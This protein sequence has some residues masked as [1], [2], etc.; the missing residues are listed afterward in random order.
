MDDLAIIHHMTPDEMDD[1]KQAT[2]R[3]FV[4]DLANAHWTM[5]VQGTGAN[6]V[7]FWLYSVSPLTGVRL[8]TQLSVDGYRL[9]MQMKD[10]PA[11]PKDFQP[12]E[13]LTSVLKEHDKLDLKGRIKNHETL[14][15]TLVAYARFTQT[16]E[17]L[18]SPGQ[19]NG[20]HF[21]IFD[22]PTNKGFHV[23]RPIALS[24]HG[25]LTQEAVVAA[26]DK[27]FDMHLAKNPGEF[28]FRQ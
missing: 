19:V 1:I 20:I 12:W 22:W 23:L 24:G 10:D 25:L 6:T 21:V 7:P 15:N 2:K 3:K 9:A 17:L 13:D 8:I 11:I 26:F 28:P 14:A 4:R 27:I 5:H 18:P 16:W